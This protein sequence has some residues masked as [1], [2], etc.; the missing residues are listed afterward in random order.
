MI[1]DDVPVSPRK[2]SG[3][4]ISCSTRRVLLLVPIGQFV[5][6]NC[7]ELN[8]AYVFISLSGRRSGTNSS[9][10]VCLNVFR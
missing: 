6:V 3:L 1:D 5:S 10:F 9:G 4:L 7:N 2:L 8:E